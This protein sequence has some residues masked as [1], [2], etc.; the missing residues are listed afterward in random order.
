MRAFH[1]A[2]IAF[3]LCFF[4][5][6]G[7]APLMPMIRDEF[8]L[9]KTQVGNI[10]IASV[11][12]TFF[13]RLLIGRICDKFG[14]RRTYA[15]LLIACSIPVA[16][17][18]L[19]QGYISFL[20]FR[21][22]IG[23]IGAGFVITQY[24]TS[25]MFAPGIVGTANATTAG[26]GDLGGGVTQLIMPL[27][28]TAL[29]SLGLNEAFSWRVA[30]VVP[31]LLLFLVGIAY[32]KLTTDTPTG[33]FEDGHRPAGTEGESVG[34]L[35]AARDYRVWILVIV[36]GACFGIVLTINNITALYF[37]DEF[38]LSIAS[39]GL[40]AASF[41]LM[42]LFARTLGGAAGDIVGKRWGVRGRILCLA[43]LLLAEGILLACFS[44]M[45]LLPLAIVTLVAFSL[46]T[47]MS[48]GATFA[49]VPFINPKAIG[50]VSG[51][52]GAG[53]NAGAVAAGFL[54]R[55]ESLATADAL[56]ILGVIVAATSGLALL[57]A[58]TV[59]SE[60]P[61]TAPALNTLSEA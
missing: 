25:I 53:G 5:W 19:S 61:S 27:L 54:F 29:L 38:G 43:L 35:R 17:I 50:S 58:A 36:Y 2:W 28:A 59:P 33:N 32:L 49:V 13:A 20:I 3:F 52:V 14:P 10:I 39:A 34:F 56:L 57:V 42:N 60:T 47:Q 45:T 31:G 41:G 51:T 48:E 23:V 8:A 1:L 9:T 4:G 16:T 15:A 37:H 11:A 55:S 44:R 6:F 22:V 12:V 40:I 21:L 7:I 18:G 24:H 26:W 46:A 30:M